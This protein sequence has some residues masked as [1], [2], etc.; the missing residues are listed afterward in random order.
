MRSQHQLADHSIDLVAIN[1]S[2]DEM[3][4]S[5]GQLQNRAL[6]PRKRDAIGFDAVTEEH[7]TVAFGYDSQLVAC[8]EDAFSQLGASRGRRPRLPDEPHKDPDV[9]PPTQMAVF[10]R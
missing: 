3:K 10:T 6:A 5:L 2:D 7:E 8:A 4:E 9:G 1:G